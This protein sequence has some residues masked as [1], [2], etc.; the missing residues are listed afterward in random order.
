MHH[1]LSRLDRSIL[2]WLHQHSTPAGISFFILL[3]RLGS[4]EAMA[5][6]AILGAGFLLFR[7]EW[8]MLAGW[9][10]AFAGTPL[11]DSWLKLAI[12]RARPVY[13]TALIQHPTWSFPSGH[14]MGAL[15][16]Y[17]MLAYTIVLL[18]QSG[19]R[20]RTVICGSA[21]LLV[22]AIGASRLY[23]G[24][25]YFTDVAGGY[26]AGLVW[27]GTCISAIEVARRYQPQLQFHP[28]G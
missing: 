9:V 27:L 19:R 24:V 26:A 21:A 6:L 17:G 10:V 4:P 18:T 14:A 22:L 1:A 16:G 3:S 28:K 5:V 20:G 7:R 15:V 11:I 25:H 23:L 2:E 13:A 8:V 12:H